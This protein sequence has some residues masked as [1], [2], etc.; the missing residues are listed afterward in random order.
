MYRNEYVYEVGISEGMGPV[1]LV[2]RLEELAV[3]R[4]LSRSRGFSALGNTL[5]QTSTTVWI[6]NPVCAYY[7]FPVDAGGM[8]CTLRVAGWFAWWLG[9]TSST[10]IP[11]RVFHV[12][13]IAWPTRYK[14]CLSPFPFPL[15]PLAILQ[16]H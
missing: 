9:T 5:K 7:S 10:A 13:G 14:T 11:L 15:W 3:S 2:C 6:K 12:H 4:P 16:L 8:V 1:G